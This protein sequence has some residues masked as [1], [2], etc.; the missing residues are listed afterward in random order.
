M[1]WYSHNSFY[2][3]R[4]FSCWRTY[5]PNSYNYS[6]WNYFHN[7]LNLGIIQSTLKPFG[8]TLDSL[9]LEASLCED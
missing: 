6:I 9:T 7:S 1:F 2:I 5:I 3:F 4:M 8:V